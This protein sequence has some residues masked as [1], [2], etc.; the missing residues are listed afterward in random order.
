MKEIIGAITNSDDE[1]ISKLVG[2]EE[3]TGH[4]VFDIRLGENFRRKARY[5]AEGQKTSTPTSMT[6]SMVVPRDSVRIISLIEALNEIELNGE[7][8]KN[9]FLSSPNKEKCWIRARPE[10]GALEGKPF[11]ITAALY[12]LKSAS[13]SFRE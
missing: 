8:V 10:F 12:G 7:D 3:I 13:A 2:Y 5:C 4:L 6:Y 9:A 11:I 1:S